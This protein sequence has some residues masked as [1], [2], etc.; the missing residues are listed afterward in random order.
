MDI[1]IQA[2]G[3]TTVHDGGNGGGEAFIQQ[4]GKNHYRDVAG[5]AI[6]NPQSRDK[7]AFDAEAF[8]R[9]GE[10]TAAAVNH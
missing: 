1:L 5:F 3:V 4:A 7:F 8:E 9:G 6:R 2:D 10:K